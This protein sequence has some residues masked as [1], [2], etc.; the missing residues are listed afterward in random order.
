M[1]PCELRSFDNKQQETPA[2]VH[3]IYINLINQCGWSH[4]GTIPF[5]RQC[6]IFAPSAK[7]GHAAHLGGTKCEAVCKKSE[8]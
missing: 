8:R 4:M 7:K 1:N 2:R 6:F 5:Q 3:T